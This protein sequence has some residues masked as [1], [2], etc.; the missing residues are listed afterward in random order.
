MSSFYPGEPQLDSPNTSSISLS[1]LQGIN[2]WLNN[3]VHKTQLDIIFIAF[4]IGLTFFL[5]SPNLDANWWIIDDHEIMQFSP[6]AHPLSFSEI[7]PTL[8]TKTDINPSAAIPRFRPVYYLFRLIETR[9]WHSVGPEGW[10]LARM[11]AF[12]IM[13]ITFYIFFKKVNGQILAFLLT[14]QISTFNIWPDIFS[15]LGPSDAYCVLGVSL[16]L[17]GTTLILSRKSN[18]MSWLVLLIGTVIAVGSKEPM[19]IML[20]PFGLILFFH[21]QKKPENKVFPII[22][23]GLSILWTVWIFFVVYT[24]LKLTSSDVYGNSVDLIAR[25]SVIFSPENEQMIWYGLVLFFA[26]VGLVGLIKSI[27]QNTKQLFRFLFLGMLGL[28][29]LLFSQQFFYTNVFLLRYRFPMLLAIPLFISLLHYVGQNL[30]K[31]NP[32]L[33]ISRSTSLVVGVVILTFF[34]HPSIWGSINESSKI[35]T[36]KTNYFISRVDIAESYLTQNPDASLVLYGNDPGSDYETSASYTEFLR[37]R[38]INNP[39]Y[40]LRDPGP[41]FE[42][43]LTGLNLTLE[44][45]LI[46]FSANGNAEWGI[47][48]AGDFF[49][50][51]TNCLLLTLNMDHPAPIRC[52]ETLNGDVMIHYDGL[53]RRW[54]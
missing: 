2:H 26:I 12:A 5:F 24:R 6:K 30:A 17:I 33:S 10:Y 29:A 13:L 34:I 3:P 43:Q 25:L 45:D 18:W 15:R 21:I 16:F 51:P 14:L 41:D 39:I 22:A 20:V 36:N 42:T 46:Q 35:N 4:F 49:T 9:I 54:E 8:L 32:I 31:T 52:Q 53:Y 23:F 11:I 44:R 28:L 47:N 1:P 50:N 37:A 19:V 40:I 48:P 27:N 7:I 38:S